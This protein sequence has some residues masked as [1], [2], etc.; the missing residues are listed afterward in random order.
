[1]NKITKAI[2]MV[3][4]QVASKLIQ[5]TQRAR[6]VTPSAKSITAHTAKK[7]KMPKKMGGL[8]KDIIAPLNT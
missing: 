5:K 8:I 3:I 2:R 6:L 7:L 1:M 4:I